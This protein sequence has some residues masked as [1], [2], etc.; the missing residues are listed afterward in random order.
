MAIRIF[1]NDEMN[2]IHH[3]VRTAEK[4]LIHGG[5]MAVLTFHSLEDRL[6]KRL[7]QQID[8]SKPFNMR[9]SETRSYKGKQTGTKKWNCHKSLLLPSGEEV[10]SNAKSRSAK[11]RIAT[12]NRNS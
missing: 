1:V 3:A 9:L 12:R 8:L 2:E 5:K 10:E 6:V 4:Y 11:L 7:F